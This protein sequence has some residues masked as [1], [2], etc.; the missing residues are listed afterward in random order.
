MLILSFGY[1][2]WCDVVN[3]CVFDIVDCSRPCDG[4]G[5]SCERSN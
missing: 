1:P 2:L 3:L 5:D 4:D